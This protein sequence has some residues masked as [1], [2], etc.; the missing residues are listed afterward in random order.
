MRKAPLV[1]TTS[2]QCNVKGARSG[3]HTQSFVCPTRIYRALLC[4]IVRK[5][6]NM[7]FMVPFV[8]GER[9]ELSV[10]GFYWGD[11]LKRCTRSIPLVGTAPLTHNGHPRSVAS[12]QGCLRGINRLKLSCITSALFQVVLIILSPQEGPLIH[13][14]DSKHHVFSFI[15]LAWCSINSWGDS[16]FFSRTPGFDWLEQSRQPHIGNPVVNPSLLPLW[17]MWEQKKPVIPIYNHY[18]WHHK[19]A[20]AVITLLPS[21]HLHTPW[22]IETKLQDAILT[23]LSTNWNA[24]LLHDEV[25]S[26]WNIVLILW[27]GS[28]LQLSCLCICPNI[29]VKLQCCAIS[30][31]C[32]AAPFSHRSV[33]LG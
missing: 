25:A 24:N 26:A 33:F 31:F 30:F 1:R 18:L 9:C 5:N 2:M 10:H 16:K 17:C 7:K 20:L 4:W 19:G 21:Q 15:C 13:D 8:N 28:L 32:W 27:I 12:F 3:T 11:N 23:L 14:F 22:A 29:G 6:S